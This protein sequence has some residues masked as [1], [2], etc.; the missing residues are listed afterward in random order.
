MH[1]LDR[2]AKR[3]LQ[4]RSRSF[5]QG[6]YSIRIQTRQSC[7]YAACLLNRSQSI[8][9]YCPQVAVCD[10]RVYMV[11]KGIYWI[12]GFTTSI[13]RPVLFARITN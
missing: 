1:K 7:S 5:A 3:Q 13:F 6:A 11:T 2:K 8:V 12:Y 9:L 4:Q 10:C